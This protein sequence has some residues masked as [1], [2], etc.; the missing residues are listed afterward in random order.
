MAGLVALLLCGTAL[1]NSDRTAL[2]NFQA[3]LD[4]IQEQDEEMEMR[5]GR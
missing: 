2:V 5:G 3:T 1:M 4:S